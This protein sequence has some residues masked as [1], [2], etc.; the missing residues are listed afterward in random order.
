MASIQQQKR[1]IGKHLCVCVVLVEKD[2]QYFMLLNLGDFQGMLE[3]CRSLSWGAVANTHWNLCSFN[4][5]RVA[6]PLL[7]THTS[8]SSQVSMR[9]GGHSGVDRGPSSCT[10]TTEVRWVHR[11]HQKNVPLFIPSGTYH[12]CFKQ[13]KESTGR[14]R[15]FLN[16]DSFYMLLKKPSLT[17]GSATTHRS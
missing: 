6:S 10:E 16:Q 3:V 9:E 1:Y 12:S 11:A 17:L 13:N 5:S 7:G 4:I 14:Q 15:F 8:N 2:K